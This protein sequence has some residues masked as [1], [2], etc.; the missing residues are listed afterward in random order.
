VARNALDVGQRHHDKLEWRSN[1]EQC[2][3][4]PD[5]QDLPIHWDGNGKSS[6]KTPMSGADCRRLVQHSWF[7]NSLP[8]QSAAQ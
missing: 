1:V 3:I 2:L 5:K 6:W 7:D 4:A 8:P